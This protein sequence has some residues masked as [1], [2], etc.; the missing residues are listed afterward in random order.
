MINEEKIRK[1][2]DGELSGQELKNFEE[3]FNRSSSLKKE[4]DDYKR[5]LNLFKNLENTKAEEEYFLNLLPHFRERFA[6]PKRLILKPS[7]A[8]GSIAMIL[9]AVFIFFIANNQKEVIKDEQMTLQNLNQDEL[10][11]YLT[12]YSDDISASQLIEDI[13]EEYDS[14]FN[15]MI[16]DEL[17][18]DNYS[19]EYFVDVSSNE[20]YNILDELS[21]EEITGIYNNLIKEDFN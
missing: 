1:Y 6:A 8:A 14:L 20:F 3:E 11:E 16:Q 17:I 9:I 15:S 10:N 19:G 2:L 7:F 4:I 13:P 18:P 12:D 5:V 21:E